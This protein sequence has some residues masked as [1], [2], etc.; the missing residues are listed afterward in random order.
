MAELPELK[1]AEIPRAARERYVG[2]RFSYMEAGRADAPP[3]VLLHGIGGNS[4]GWRFQYP[5]L[6]DRF[7]VIA[8][9]A[10]GYMLSDPLR[11]EMPPADAFPSA[12]DDFLTA[13]GIAEFDVLANSFGT[14]VVQGFAA[15]HRGRIKHAVFTGTSVAR[16]QS[17]E[18]RERAIA[19]RAAQ[20]ASGG[21]GFGERVAALLGSR[22]TPETAAIVQHVLRATNPAGFMQAARSL[23]GSGTPPGAGLTMPL[24]LIQG[25]DDR[26]TPSTDNAEKLVAAVPRARLVGL[27]GIGHLPEIET[28]DRVNRL[29]LDF[30]SAA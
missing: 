14:R 21:Y 23:T 9:N 25:G 1:F 8:W 3:L 29:V 24:L 22:A 28:P 15:R 6:A 17:P 4:L 7:R 13:L 30:L 10:P 18:E 26:V 11:V 20:V 12:L 16:E 19:A 27:E 2:D 5:A